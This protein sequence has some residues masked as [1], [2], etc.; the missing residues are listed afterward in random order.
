MPVLRPDGPVTTDLVDGEPE[1]EMQTITRTREV[2]TY[3]GPTMDV[4]D[5]LVKITEALTQLKTAAASATTY[6]E[7]QTAIDTALADV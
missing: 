2:K 5:T 1:Q 6:E 3:T 7:L 4:K